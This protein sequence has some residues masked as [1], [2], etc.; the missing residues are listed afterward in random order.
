M[1]ITQ[2]FANRRTV[3]RFHDTAFSLD[4]VKRLVWAA[5]GSTG[6]DGKRTVSS[7]DALYPLR[8]LV[9]ASHVERLYQE[10]YEVDSK[11]LSLKS[12]ANGNVRPA[13][14]LAAVDQP[15]W[16]IEAART[17]IICAD[18]IAPNHAFSKQRP[19]GQHDLRYVYLEAGAAARDVRLAWMAERREIV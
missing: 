12:L 6:D 5:Q 16:T 14:Q 4:T 9:A 11:D 1:T 15:H 7:A 3:R 2:A 10:L 13:L 19:Y 17:I 18:M 8:L